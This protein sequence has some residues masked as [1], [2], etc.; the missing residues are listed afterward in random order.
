[1]SPCPDIVFFVS[2]TKLEVWHLFHTTCMNVY[3]AAGLIMV[4]VPAIACRDA[5][6]TMMYFR[7]KADVAF[8]VCFRFVFP[9][10]NVFEIQQIFFVF[11]PFALFILEHK[12]VFKIIKIILLLKTGKSHSSPNLLWN[13]NIESKVDVS[14][15]HAFEHSWKDLRGQWWRYVY[16]GLTKSCMRYLM[17]KDIKYMFQCV[18]EW[19]IIVFD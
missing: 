16:S 14:F 18:Q 15:S 12:Y 19:N 2:F 9:Y 13:L 8:F 1:M 10:N 3:H 17:R 6:I 5:N 4:M 11:L 7:F